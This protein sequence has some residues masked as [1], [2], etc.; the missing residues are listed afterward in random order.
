[1]SVSP[2]PADTADV[3]AAYWRVLQLPQSVRLAMQRVRHHDRVQRGYLEQLTQLT[4]VYTLL[5]AGGDE[6]RHLPA[7]CP[8]GATLADVAAA[9]ARLEGLVLEEGARKARLVQDC[10][11]E[12]QRCEAEVVAKIGGA[13]LT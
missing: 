7:D 11:L 5:K 10:A 9:I 2:P 8:P 13:G 4:R 3:L 1:M 12:L 6:A